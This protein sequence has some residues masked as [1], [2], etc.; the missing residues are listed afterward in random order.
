MYDAHPPDCA[1]HG[2]EQPVT[3]VKLGQ[4]FWDECAGTGLSDAAVR[5]HGEAI[6]WV[7]RIEQTNLVIRK[8]L[9]PR[10]AGSPQWE[11]G[12]A[13]LIQVGYWQDRGDSYV[14]VHHADVIRASITAQQLLRDRNKRSQQAHRKRSSEQGVSA[15]VSAAPVSQTDSQDKEGI[16][17]TEKQVTT[18]TEEV[19]ADVA[20]APT[21]LLQPGPGKEGKEDPVAAA[22]FGNGE[23]AA[24]VSH[25]ALWTGEGGCAH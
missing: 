11:F 20:A 9:V 7:Y 22:R 14:I 13:E 18:R 10:F 3:W 16:T 21:G 15:D 24:D 8:N 6:G 12:I 19:R 2:G 1:P 4:E 25:W 5:T 17:H 23:V